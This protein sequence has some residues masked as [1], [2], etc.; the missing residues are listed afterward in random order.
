M[1]ISRTPFRI[2]FVGGGTDLRDYYQNDDYGAVISSTIDKYMYITVNKRFDS[3]IRASY[4]HTEIVNHAS[5]INHPIIREALRATGIDHGVEITSIADI[6]AQ[7]GLG[8][9][10]A[11]TVGLLHAL[12]AYRGVFRSAQDLAEEACRIEIDILHE[13][14]GKQDQYAVAFGGV[15]HIQFNK[16][17]SVFVNPVICPREVKKE[18]KE[19]LLLFY[20]GQTRKASSVLSEQKKNTANRSNILKSMREM[21]DG[22][23]QIVEEGRQLS[24]VGLLLHEGWAFKKMMAGGISTPHIDQYYERAVDAGALGG[25]VLGAGGGGFLLFYCERHNQTRLREELKELRE[26]QFQFEPEGSKIIFV[27]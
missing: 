20:T 17:E 25:K 15:N 8:S 1:I 9:S 7:T 12:Y 6:P 4:A 27:G 10:S 14:I 2:S 26:I 24:N 11:F 23:R 3:T 19:N 21:V 18:L 22:F 5:E 13:P 16:D